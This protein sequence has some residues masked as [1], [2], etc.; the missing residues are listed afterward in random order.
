MGSWES[1][2]SK[3]DRNQ[4]GLILEQV[5]K[6][7]GELFPEWELSVISLDKRQDRNEQLMRIIEVLGK[8]REIT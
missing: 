5:L 8:M 6:R 2:L 7:H 4:I 3:A 1:I